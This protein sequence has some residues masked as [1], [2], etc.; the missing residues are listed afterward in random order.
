MHRTGTP[1]IPSR[2]GTPLLATL[3][4][5]AAAHSISPLSGSKAKDFQARVLETIDIDLG[6]F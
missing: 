4:K 6:D 3:N 2:A 5:E 1:G